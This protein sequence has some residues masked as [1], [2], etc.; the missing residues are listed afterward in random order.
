MDDKK[1]EARFSIFR[2]LCLG[3]AWFQD[4]PY[5]SMPQPD[6]KF[7]P[8]LLD[9]SA[10]PAVTPVGLV[11]S[12]RRIRQSVSDLRTPWLGAAI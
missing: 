8:S 6:G 11:P 1:A 2:Q 9:V 5:R 10:L 4:L 3:A 12:K 7:S